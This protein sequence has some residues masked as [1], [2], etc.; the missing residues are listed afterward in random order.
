VNKFATDLS[1][2]FGSTSQYFTATGATFG[3]DAKNSFKFLSRAVL[4]V[5][6]KKLLNEDNVKFLLKFIGQVNATDLLKMVELGAI[7]V[8]FN[9]S[10]IISSTVAATVG[11]PLDVKFDIPY[12][13]GGANIN[14]DPFV[15]VAV[16]GIKFSGK[17]P[18]KLAIGASA[19]IHDTEDIATNIE[20]IVDAVLHGK[21]LPGTIGGGRLLFGLDGSDA[22]I[23]DTFSTVSLDLSLQKIGGPILAQILAQINKVPFPQTAEEIKA[24]LAKL[25]IAPGA[26]SVVAKEKKTIGASAGVSFNNPFSITVEGLSFLTAT[27]GINGR[28]VTKIVSNGAAIVPSNN[29]L[30]LAADLVFISSDVIKDLVKTF[31]NNVISNFGQTN[32][33][34]TAGG[35]AF[36]FDAEHSFKFLSRAVLGVPSKA[37]L[38]EKNLNT[39]LALVGQV[40]TTQLLGMVKL[41]GLSAEFHPSTVID[42]KVD[43]EVLVPLDIKFNMPFFK[44]S[45]NVN[46]AE[47]VDVSVSGLQ[48]TGKG[49]NKLAI[50]AAAN[51]HDTE[52]IAINIASIVDAVLK[53]KE[54]P[55]TIGGG[56]LLFVSFHDYN[57]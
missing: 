3:F 51:I 10:S 22:N 52:D 21:E 56:K 5:P 50:G 25:G 47:F 31:V 16:S 20:N 32:E 19:N 13:R 55:G 30:T 46:A 34:F 37:V 54:L 2:N 12:F 36:G 49:P 29:T 1:N 24:L 8:K 40:N 26:I 41:G 38:N 23:I 28:A 4:G 14:E 39:T 6:S 35:V 11:L 33:F 15:D 57:F 9:Q 27:A 7:G 17:G 44:T 48:L 45:A 42:T 53:G 43:A 18:N